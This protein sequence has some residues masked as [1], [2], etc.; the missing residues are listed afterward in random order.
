MSD[1]YVE[2]YK[3]SVGRILDEYGKEIEKIGQ[4]LAPIN[5]D[6][7]KLEQIKPPSPDDKK[8]IE[9][10]TKKREAVRKKFDAA[11]MSLKV[12]LMMIAV[13]VKADEKELVKLPAWMKEIIKKK[14]IPLGKDVTI[15]PDVNFDFKAKKLKSLGITVKW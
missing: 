2:N 4:E 14:G 1:I 7:H 5:A 6:L 10:L 12:D 15:A 8:K 9:D 11:A 13:P 3:K